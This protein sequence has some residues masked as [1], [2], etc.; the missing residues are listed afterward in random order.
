MRSLQLA[1]TAISRKTSIILPGIAAD[2]CHHAD[3]DLDLDPCPPCLPPQVL[4]FHS[5][6][7]TEDAST[8]CLK[9]SIICALPIGP[10]VSLDPDSLDGS[11]GRGNFEPVSVHD[12]AALYCGKCCVTP[13]QHASSPES[14]DEAGGTSTIRVEKARSV[15]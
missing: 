15:S 13:R 9:P 2:E 5:P 1:P 6:E 11:A 14:R 3:L 10:W 7:V 8:N 4:P 12:N